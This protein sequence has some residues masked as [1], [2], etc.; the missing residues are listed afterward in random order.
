MDAV[1]LALC[2]AA[3]FGGDDRRPPSRARPWRRPARAARS[4]RSC[5]RSASRSSRPLIAG[6]WNVAAVWPFAL[7]GHPRARGL[8][9]PLHVR[10]PRRRAVARRPRPSGWRRSSP[11]RSRSSSSVSRS[12]PGI[13]RRGRADRRRRRRARER[14]RPARARED[15]RPRLRARRRRSCSP[16]ATPSS[17]GSRSTPTSLRSSRSAPPCSA[18]ALTILV[19]VLVGRAPARASRSL[20]RVRAAGA[21]L[22]ALVRLALRGVLP[23]PAQRRR[24]PRRDR[25]ALGRGPLGALP[26]PRRGRRPPPRRSAR[27]FVVA[28]GILIGFSR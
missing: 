15:D 1:V 28:G 13:A 12:S 23:R 3:L 9:G 8:A 17:A 7:A 19:A 26:A 16:R 4:S 27:C 11:S 6:D 21:A 10:D 22:R 18:G 25:V 20:A 2:S 14:V 5:P 24:A